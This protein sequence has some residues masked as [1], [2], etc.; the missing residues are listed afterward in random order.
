[1]FIV[2]DELHFPSISATWHMRRNISFIFTLGVTRFC[3]SNRGECKPWCQ[4]NSF[5]IIS[6]SFISFI[7]VFFILVAAS[8]S[9]VEFLF[10]FFIVCACSCSNVRG[11]DFE[12]CINQFSQTRRMGI[13]NSFTA[14]ARWS[15]KCFGPQ[16]DV[17]AEPIIWVPTARN[18]QI[19]SGLSQKEQMLQRNRLLRHYLG[20]R[21]QGKRL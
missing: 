5:I 14:I 1:M 17:I 15:G 7:L 10:S 21:K 2:T 16:P 19:L 8:K 6:I 12:P 13:P 9:G 3:S 4:I 20:C 11:P 18:N